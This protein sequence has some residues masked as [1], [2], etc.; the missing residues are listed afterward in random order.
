MIAKGNR[1]SKILF[2]LSTIN[3]LHF[4]KFL[5]GIVRVAYVFYFEI[6]GAVPLNIKSWHDLTRGNHMDVFSDARL[7]PKD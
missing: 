2:F 5:L 6:F 3:F 4:Q 7:S 1:I